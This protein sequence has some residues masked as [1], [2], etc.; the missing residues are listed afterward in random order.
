MNLKS[1][2]D[3]PRILVTAI[4][5]PYEPWISILRNGQ[6]PTWM[7]QNGKVRVVNVFGRSVADRY[8]PVD[9]KLYFLRWNESR[10]IAYFSLLIEAV[11]KKFLMVNRYQPKIKLKVDDTFGEVWEVQQPDSLLLQGVKNIATLR[12][13]LNHE[14]DFLITTITSTYLNLDQ[15][16]NTLHESSRVQFIGGR[17]ES[18]GGKKF[19][20]GSF[21]VYS[22][23]VVEYI[24]KNSKKYK[25]W[26]IEDIAMGNVVAAKY[27]DFTEMPNLTI[28]CPEDLESIDPQSM[29]EVC[30]FRCKSQSEDGVRADALI[31]KLI[32]ARLRETS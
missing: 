24:V 10:I 22:R 16:S 12:E 29:I 3:S 21:R 28:R 27:R 25:H 6:I 17:I 2:V 7:K 9:Q 1:H 31:M 20:Q 5:G 26:Q 15:I 13:S 11:I 30:S 18:S 23:D 19:Q 8:L 32:S 4:H 14:F